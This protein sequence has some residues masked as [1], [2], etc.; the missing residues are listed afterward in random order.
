[1]KSG[2]E[3]AREQRTAGDSRI[4]LYAG[5]GWRRQLNE[6]NELELMFQYFWTRERVRADFG[7]I[8]LGRAT[9]FDMVWSRFQLTANYYFLFGKSGKK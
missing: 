1:M 4:G 6:N 2:F 7:G 8:Y 5:F 3:Y 9:T